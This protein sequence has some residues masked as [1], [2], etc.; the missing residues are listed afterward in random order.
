MPVDL[1]LVRGRGAGSSGHA[2]D[3]DPEIYAAAKERQLRTSEDAKRL[4]DKH[5]RDLVSPFS[6]VR[7]KAQEALVDETS[8]PI[9]LERIE[10]KVAVV[11]QAVN[12]LRAANY[13]K[14][15]FGSRF[16]ENL[17]EVTGTFAE[18]GAGQLAAVKGIRDIAQGRLRDTDSLRKM[19]A[20]EIAKSG[21]NPL[22][23]EIKGAIPGVAH[24][25]I[26]GATGMLPDIAA[27]GVA[28]SVGAT[29]ALMGYW[30]GRMAPEQIEELRREG[31]GEDVAIAQGV[32]IA[33]ASAAIESLFD[34]T[35][36]AR[37]LAG[38]LT[39]GLGKKAVDVFGTKLSGVGSK[40]AGRAAGRAL[41]TAGEVVEEGL[42]EGATGALEYLSSVTSDA[43]KDR[44]AADIL[45]DAWSAMTEA[46]P[47]VALLGGGRLIAGFGGDIND[48]QLRLK[49]ATEDIVAIAQANETPSRKKWEDR[50]SVV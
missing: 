29:P 37:G 9:L 49:Q 42:Q 25:M 17:G 10:R 21:N 11:S 40:I 27:G 15:G 2:G 26:T 30:T 44:D 47:G 39:R 7:R 3:V 1:N 23:K 14:K 22:A 36:S 18:A 50:K 34:P 28:A 46:A 5:L 33:G 24:K 31:L 20:F 43:F 19:A 35:G 13:S 4:E 41:D 8:S 32:G 16:M 6:S 48:E 12:M 38:G 45:P